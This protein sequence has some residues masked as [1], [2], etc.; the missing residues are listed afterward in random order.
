M[1]FWKAGPQSAAP[2]EGVIRHPA[3]G[4]DGGEISQVH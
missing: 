2:T 4:R 1:N 3:I